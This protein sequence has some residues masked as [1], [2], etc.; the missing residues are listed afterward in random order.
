M[1]IRFRKTALFAAAVS[2]MFAP[3][4]SAQTAPETPWPNDD[5]GISTLTWCTP[6][7]FICTQCVGTSEWQVCY[8][9]ARP[10]ETQDEVE[11]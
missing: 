2:L 9:I 5:D 8:P 10:T 4:A 6:G 11:P 7:S 3:V 1:R